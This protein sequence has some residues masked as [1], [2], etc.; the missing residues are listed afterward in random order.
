V[1]P[2]AVPTRSIHRSAALLVAGA[3]AAALAGCGGGE[4]VTTVP[5]GAATADGDAPV[6]SAPGP[7]S[8]TSEP[9]DKPTDKPTAEPT[10]EPTATGSAAQADLT[11][12]VDDGAGTSST[13]TLTCDDGQAGGTLPTASDACAQLAELGPQA[14][15]EPAADQMCTDIYGGPQTATVTGTVD[16]A[17]VEVTLSRTNGCQISRWDA[18]SAIVGRA[19]APGT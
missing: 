1:R 12:V 8:T 4:D 6:T 17:P 16:A 11:V 18:L 2:P 5:G 19:G 14:F 7:S 15:A 13:Y 10:G 9:T 3:A